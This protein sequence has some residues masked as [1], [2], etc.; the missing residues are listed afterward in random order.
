MIPSILLHKQKPS[1]H[2]TTH[3]EENYILIWTYVDERKLI[4]QSDKSELLSRRM[5]ST[6]LHVQWS[7]SQENIKDLRASNM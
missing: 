2:N 7:S 4:T 1:K 3:L 6:N 5:H